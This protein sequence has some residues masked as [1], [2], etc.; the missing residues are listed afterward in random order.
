MKHLHMRSGGWK[1]FEDLYI[2]WSGLAKPKHQTES[3][4][5]NKD[6]FVFVARLATGITEFDAAP[7]PVE[8]SCL[9]STS[10]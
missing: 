3:Y 2:I 8:S 1:I 10:T 4:E 5:L 7:I 9:W 6:S